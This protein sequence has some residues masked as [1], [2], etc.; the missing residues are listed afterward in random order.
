MLKRIPGFF[1]LI[2]QLVLSTS[3]AALVAYYNESDFQLALDTFTLVNLD[4]AP[5][6]TFSAPYN[7]QDAGP[8]AAF[9]AAGISSFDANHQVLAGNDYQTVKNNRDH[10]IANGSG[11]GIGDMVINFANPV[12]GVGAW[13]NLDPQL[14]GDGGEI[15]A[16]NSSGVEIGRVAFGTSPAMAGGFSGLISDEAIVSAEITCTFNN[17][18]KCGVYDIQFGISPVPIPTAAWLFGS[19]LLGLIGV[20]RSK[21]TA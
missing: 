21:K 15:I 18:F 11:F 2:G 14:G 1:F 12:N 16:Y 5:F 13:T 8:V 19:G 17:D 20:A 6:N 3:H 10:L 9:L 7:V 4:A